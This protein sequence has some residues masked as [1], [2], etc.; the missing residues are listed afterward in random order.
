MLSQHS[1]GFLAQQTQGALML[2]E[3]SSAPSPGCCVW[4]LLA[5]PN[6]RAGLALEATAKR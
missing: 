6:P 3:S 5:R 2:A 4:L 1:Q